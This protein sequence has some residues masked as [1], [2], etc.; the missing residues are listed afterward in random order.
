MAASRS[1]ASSIPT[2]PICRIEVSQPGTRGQFVVTSGERAGRVISFVHQGLPLSFG[3]GPECTARFEVRS[4]S[5]LHARAV[6]IGDQHFITDAGSTHGTFVNDR[7][8][9]STVALEPGDTIRLG[10]EVTM[11]FAIFDAREEESLIRAG[12]GRDRDPITG[13]YLRSH[14]EGVI[15]AGLRAGRSS[16]ESLSV[17]L[18][19]LTEFARIRRSLG[20]VA[21]DQVLAGLGGLA[22]SWTRG[23]D[24]LGRFDDDSLMIIVPG[25]K[26]G[27][28]V[29]IAERVQRDVSAMTFAW[30][31]QPLSIHVGIGVASLECCGSSATMPALVA[32]AAHRA[33]LAER[34][35]SGVVAAGGI[36]PHSPRSPSDFPTHAGS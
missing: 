2:N 8:A 16:G 28:A 30:Q 4:I 6:W 32:L 26:L 27:D 33:S 36:L 21:A 34:T 22:S 3:R 11:S 20:L 10:P 14:L 12:A 17:I 19:R 1:S 23:S 7:R 29:R 5:R 13:L 15:D 25:A 24:T 9:D 31:S 35:R 18:V